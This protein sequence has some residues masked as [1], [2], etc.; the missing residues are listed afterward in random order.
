MKLYLSSRQTTA[1]SHSSLDTRGERKT[2]Y[3][4]WQQRFDNCR[5]RLVA[6]LTVEVVSGDVGSDLRL[7]SVPIGQ[8]LLLVV[9]KL[10]VR[11]CGVL[12]VGSL[13]DRIDRARLLAEA[14]EDA[15]SHIDIVACCT[16]AAVCARLC[17]NGDG[18]GGAN[19]F[20]K[21]A[22]YTALLPARVSSECMFSTET[23]AQRSSLEGIV[24]GDLWLEVVLDS[25]LCGAKH[26]GEKEGP[27]GPIDHFQNSLI[28]DGI[29]HRLVFLLRDNDGKAS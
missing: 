26:L 8:Q 12:K 22:G 13:H 7:P 20:A 9:Q 1:T 24:D 18:L 19:S 2:R 14:A 10:F 15:L 17:L 6:P 4:E 25:E 16:A 23:R 27:G 28:V 21:L 3:F 11:L 5:L 29:R